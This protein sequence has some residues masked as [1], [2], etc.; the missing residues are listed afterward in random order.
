MLYVYLPMCCDKDSSSNDLF[1]RVEE[2]EAK[3]DILESHSRR[4]NLKIFGL[5]EGRRE[6]YELCTDKVIGFLNN[7]ATHKVWSYE[8]I[9]RAH[10]LGRQNHR[11][12]QPRPVIIKFYRWH[13]KLRLLQDHRTRNAMRRDGYRLAADITRQQ[14]A[15]LQNLKHEGKRGYY[16]NGKLHVQQDSRRRDRQDR[17]GQWGDR[18]LQTASSNRGHQGNRRRDWREDDRRQHSRREDNDGWREGDDDWRGDSDDWRNEEYDTSQRNGPVDY[19]NGY[20]Y[21]A[22]WRGYWGYPNYMLHPHDWP[23]LQSG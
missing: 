7:Y 10:R 22:H 6:T 2:L 13:D 18:Q 15:Q 9:E 3:L 21:D 14:A 8:D 19:D 23:P 17:Q 20:G 4:N 16:R 11:R 5:E 12:K 1:R